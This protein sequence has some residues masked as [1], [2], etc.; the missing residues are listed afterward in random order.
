MSANPRN[1]PREKHMLEFEEFLTSWILR[2]IRDSSKVASDLRNS[3]PNYFDCS[4][5]HTF[6]DII[7]TLIT[8]EIVK[9][10]KES[11]QETFE[12]KP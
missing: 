2:V 11:L 1:R 9:V 7:Y 5:S 3:L 6:T 8:H 10:N 12:R 4:F